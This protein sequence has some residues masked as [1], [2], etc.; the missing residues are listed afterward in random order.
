MIRRAL[1]VIWFAACCSVLAFTLHAY[2]PG[3]QGDAGIVFAAA[4]SALTFP[5]GLLV[6]GG[7][8]AL[9]AFYDGSRL[10][11]IDDLPDTIGL[12]VLWLAFCAIGYFQ[13]FRVMSQEV[14]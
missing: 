1:L 10:A 8:G 6:S 5:T 13:W 11:P 4:M 7:V 9:A 2:A 14:V 12:T 3:P